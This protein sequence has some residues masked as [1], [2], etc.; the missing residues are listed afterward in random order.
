MNKPLV[1][2]T[3][4]LTILA[5]CSYS[6]KPEP[7]PASLKWI[8]RSTISKLDDSK[9]VS[10]NVCSR[11]YCGHDIVAEC[12]E[13]KTSVHIRLTGSYEGYYVPPT[14]TYRIDSEK[15]RT[16]SSS[17]YGSSAISFLKRL[18]GRKKIYI[19]NSIY[20]GTFTLVGIRTALVQL[21]TACNW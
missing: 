10:I 13:G 20:D 16:T 12:Q 3:L 5:N 19:V 18:V 17:L 1:S 9:N 4:A 8:T 2:T 6:Y 11:P 21:R 14:A 15:A 7:A